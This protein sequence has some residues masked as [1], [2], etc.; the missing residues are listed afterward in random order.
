MVTSP[1]KAHTKKKAS[2]YLP[3]KF[4]TMTVQNSGVLTPRNRF[5]QLEEYS[6]V[7]TETKLRHEIIEK[8]FEPEA[9]ADFEAQK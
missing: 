1:K 6:S 5:P 2:K 3:K 8:L 9:L 7:A 4:P